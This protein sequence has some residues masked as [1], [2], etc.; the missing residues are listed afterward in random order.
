DPELMPIGLLLRLQGKKVTYDVHEDVPGQIRFSLWIPRW[1]SGTAAWIFER[2][3]RFASHRF[4]AVVTANEDLRARFANYT[5]RVVVL[6]NYPLLQEL[7]AW[8]NAER[9]PHSTPVI[10]DFGGVSPQTSAG[11]IVKAMGLLPEELRAT[12]VLGGFTVSGTLLQ[13]ISRLSGWT[14]VVH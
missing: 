8:D 10:V 1:M 9:S 2:L 12:L 7:A 4:A 14:R 3:E 13:E 5:R 11:P 6:R